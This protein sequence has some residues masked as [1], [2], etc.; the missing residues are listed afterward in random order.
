MTVRTRLHNSNMHEFQHACLHERARSSSTCMNSS[1]HE[2]LNALAACTNARAAFPAAFE[3]TCMH[4]CTSHSKTHA[5][6]KAHKTSA[7][8][9]A[10]RRDALAPCLHSSGRPGQL[11]PGAGPGRLL[12]ESSV[13]LAEPR[14]ASRAGRY[15]NRARLP[16][17][18]PVAPGAGHLAGVGSGRL[19]LRRPSAPHAHGWPE[20]AQNGPPGPRRLLREGSCQDHRAQ[21]CLRRHLCPRPLLLLHPL[22]RGGFREPGL[23]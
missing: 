19:P 16:C 13:K 6:M 9:N 18:S 5:C 17:A 15:P 23:V 4:E 21:L 20:H 10:L 22:R 12:S 1:R 2:C 14:A 7:C 11:V 8:I 3:D